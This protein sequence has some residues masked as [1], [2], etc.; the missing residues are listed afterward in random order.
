MTEPDWDLMHRVQKLAAFKVSHA[1]WPHMRAQPYGRILNV[2]STA[3][4]G[5]FGQANYASAKSGL[6]GFTRTLATKGARYG[7]QA[8][9]IAHWPGLA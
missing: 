6:I 1:A 7:I 9:L 5:N 3:I 4:Y 8:N 2:A